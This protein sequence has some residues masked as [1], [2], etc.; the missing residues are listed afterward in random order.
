MTWEHQTETEKYGESWRLRDAELPL[1]LVV[2]HH[3]KLYSAC[4][5]SLGKS[6][7]VGDVYSSAGGA[8][9]AC[10]KRLRKAG[11]IT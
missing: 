10:V 5:Y 1:A 2:K 11:V 7:K 4:I 6:I 3:E 9:A 8:K